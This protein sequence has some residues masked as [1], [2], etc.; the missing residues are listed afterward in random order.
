[1]IQV[2]SLSV[3]K[4]LLTTLIPKIL[5]W[6]F[7]KTGNKVHKATILRKPEIQSK[8]SNRGSVITQKGGN[9]Q[10]V[11]GRFKTEGTYVHLW[12][13]HVVVG[14]KSN[15]Y[16][17]PINQKLV[18]KK[19]TEQQQCLYS[20]IKNHCLWKADEKQFYCF[21]NFQLVSQIVTISSKWEDI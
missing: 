7:N 6:N 19:D 14:Q 9:R 1:M 18:L 8:N 3:A 13:I 15:Q 4:M 20:C 11:G 10:E 21:F 12:L 2:L 17:K 5:S 16:C